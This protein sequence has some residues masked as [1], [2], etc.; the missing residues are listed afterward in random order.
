MAAM[1]AWDGSD[2]R[3][4]GRGLYKTG[5]VSREGPRQAS[6]CHATE[7]AP[8]VEREHSSRHSLGQG[9]MVAEPRKFL[10]VFPKYP[11]L[12]SATDSPGIAGA[13][14]HEG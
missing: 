9:I 3:A 8:F 4:A 14:R 13:E 2:L 5:V 1:P 11:A 10:A 12:A 6:R 7:Q